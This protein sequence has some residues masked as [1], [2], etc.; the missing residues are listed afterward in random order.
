M[1]QDCE[2]DDVIE[3]GRVSTA[4]EGSAGPFEDSEGSMRFKPGLTDD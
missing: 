2:N 1:K 4:T 3:F